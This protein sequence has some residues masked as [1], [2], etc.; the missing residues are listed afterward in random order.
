MLDTPRD[1][2]SPA[3]PAQTAGRIAIGLAVLATAS[4]VAGAAGN[5]FSSLAGF[6]LLFLW[7]VPLIVGIV[8]VSQN[9]PQS[10]HRLQVAL[11]WGLCFLIAWNCLGV[12]LQWAGD[13]ALIANPR[14]LSAYTRATELL[15]WPIDNFS[16]ELRVAFSIAVPLGLMFKSLPMA[17]SGTSDASS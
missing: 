4:A 15:H 14:H 17:Q 3:L 7:L 16:T 13:H 10:S 11:R 2:N 6:A 5:Q 8:L 1:Q 9:L 12:G